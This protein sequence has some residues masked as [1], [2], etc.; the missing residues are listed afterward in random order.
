MPQGHGQHTHKSHPQPLLT[1]ARGNILYQIWICDTPQNKA[2]NTNILT[3]FIVRFSKFK[4]IG[5]HLQ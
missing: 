1:S 3:W 2:K 5:N 4:N